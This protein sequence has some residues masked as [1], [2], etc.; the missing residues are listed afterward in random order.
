MEGFNLLLEH[1]AYGLGFKDYW[2]EAASLK[3]SSRHPHNMFL[4][5]GIR[6]GVVGLLLWVGLWLWAGWRAFKHRQAALGSAAVTL[7]LYSGLVAL[8]EGTAPWVK[9]G[10]IW[11]VTWLPIAMALVIDMRARSVERSRTPLA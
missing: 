3:F 10:P 9:P 4:D 11:F 2:V 1:W 8:T 6:F 5:I 7:W